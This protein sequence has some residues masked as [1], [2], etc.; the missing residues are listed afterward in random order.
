MNIFSPVSA[1]KLPVMVFLHG[2]HY[3]QGGAGMLL[4]DGT[5]LANTSNVVVVTMNYR[6]GILGFL[7]LDDY[8]GN[9]GALH[10]C[11]E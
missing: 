6:L 9:F 10:F 11:F 7:A 2:G 3:D 8:K 4:Y 5:I 1:N